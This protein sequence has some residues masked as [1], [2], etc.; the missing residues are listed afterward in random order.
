MG[1]YANSI[2]TIRCQ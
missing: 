2:L 1:D